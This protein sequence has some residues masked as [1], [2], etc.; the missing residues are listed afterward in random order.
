MTSQALLNAQQLLLQYRQRDGVT[1]RPPAA[2]IDAA[3]P[4][5][6]C[7]PALPLPVRVLPEKDTEQAAARP[8]AL[9]A[10]MAHHGDVA[11]AAMHA[12]QS[13]HYQL[14]LL[15]RFL[16][17]EGA[18][19]VDG[20]ALRLHLTAGASKHQLY[21]APRLR[22]LLVEGDGRYWQ[23]PADGSRA[24]IYYAST[25]ALAF[26]L[27][28]RRL[29]GRFATITAAQAKAAAAEFRAWCFAAWLANRRNPITQETIERLT[30]ISPRTQRR[31]ARLARIDPHANVAIGPRRTPET[32]QEQAW[33]RGTGYFEFTDH[34]GK[35][36]PAGRVYCAWH[37][38]NGYAPGVE[39]GSRSQQRSANRRLATLVKNG[40]RGNRQ[41]A[42]SHTRLFFENGSQAAQ[43]SGQEA[44]WRGLKARTGTALWYVQEGG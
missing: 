19:R 17:Q 6:A 12:G 9:R 32:A 44:Y 16:D 15:M 25:A 40:A 34:L 33:R 31:Y 43:G 4:A 3:R 18:G 24:N 1:Y 41:A 20:E 28:V 23:L 29:S 22:Q 38:P 27:G 5:A 21:N 30:G 2:P 35:Q 39:T 42:G 36:G 26:D 8:S 13:S 7:A 10:E 37:L 11:I 14:W